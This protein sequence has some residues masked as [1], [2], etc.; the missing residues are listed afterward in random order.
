MENRVCHL[1]SN[2]IAVV[3]DRAPKEPVDVHDVAAAT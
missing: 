3:A 2:P 1:D